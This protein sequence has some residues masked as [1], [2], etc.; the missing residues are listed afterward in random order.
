M[1][2]PTQFDSETELSSVNSIL[3]I[4]GQ[5]P[6][7]SLEFTNPEVAFIYQLLGEASKDIQNEGWTFNT[8]LHYP[9]ERDTDNKISIS[10][11]M[12]RVD[13]SDGQIAKFHDPIKRQGFLYDKINHTYIWDQD[14]AADIVWWFTYEDLP[15]VFKRYATY[16]A[17]TRAATQMVGNP[18]LVQLLAAQEVQA[19]AACMEYECNQGDYNMFGFGHNTSYTAY[20]PHQGLNRVV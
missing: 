7:T 10:N 5:A 19:R 3:G 12:L 16:K 17:G 14:I 6:I 2:F 1:T 15:S 4:I 8:E 9:L 18:Q 20:K 11:N 13:I